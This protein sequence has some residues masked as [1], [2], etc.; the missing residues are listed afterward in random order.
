MV[1]VTGLHSLTERTEEKVLTHSE[2]RKRLPSHSAHNKVFEPTKNRLSHISKKLSRQHKEFPSSL[3]TGRELLRDTA[4]LETQ[5]TNIQ[6]STD[7]PGIQKKRNLLSHQLKA[8]TLEYLNMEFN[9]T[10]WT[11]VYT[12]G[13]AEDAVSVRNGSSGIHIRFPDG[14][15][16]STSLPPGQLSTNYRAEQTALLE[17]AEPIC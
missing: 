10:Q 9:V 12:D 16:V 14:R 3:P 11:H 1:K 5:P 7:I 13:S 6:I 4:N 2:K 15:C 17:A 8:L